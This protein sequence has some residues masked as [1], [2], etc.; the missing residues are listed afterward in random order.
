MAEHHQPIAW[1]VPDKTF[2]ALDVPY[3]NPVE[4]RKRGYR[5]WV[6]YQQFVEV[7]AETVEEAMQKTGVFEPVK[8]E[9]IGVLDVTFY[10]EEQLD[11]ISGHGSESRMA[12]AMGKFTF[13]NNDTIIQPNVTPQKPQESTGQ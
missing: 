7:E 6:D 1:R 12:N 2:V 11:K 9:R 10:Q 3:R 5:V 8:M 13:F 4:K